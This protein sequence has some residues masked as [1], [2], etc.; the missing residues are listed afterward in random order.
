MTGGLAEEKVGC[1]LCRQVNMNSEMPFPLVFAR[2][3]KFKRGF[4]ENA[5]Q[6]AISKHA[7]QS[8]ARTLLLRDHNEV[9]NFVNRPV[10]P[11]TPP[12]NLRLNAVRPLIVR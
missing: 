3:K 2:S 6:L 5:D 7:P 11:P 4:E 1:P 9:D 10:V 8:H 12:P